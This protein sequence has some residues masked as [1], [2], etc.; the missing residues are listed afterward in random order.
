M[1][2]VLVPCTC[3]LLLAC[4]CR[5]YTDGPSLAEYR[6]CDVNGTVRCDGEVIQECVDGYWEDIEDCEAEE[7]VCHEEMGHCM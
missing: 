2:R 5:E 6:A 1:R 7:R 4:G 3:F